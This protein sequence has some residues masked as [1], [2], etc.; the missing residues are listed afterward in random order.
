[1]SKKERMIRTIARL[2]KGM[3]VAEFERL[4]AGMTGDELE[5]WLVT[6]EKRGL[7]KEKAV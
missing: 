2:F 1:M 6:A 4:F 7:F 3:T 5:A